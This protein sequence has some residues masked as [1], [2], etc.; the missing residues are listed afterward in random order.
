MSIYVM[1]FGPDYSGIAQANASLVIL[2]QRC[3]AGEHVNETD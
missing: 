2:D 1:P 3:W